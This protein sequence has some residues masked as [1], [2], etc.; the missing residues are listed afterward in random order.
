M[1][2]RIFA[3]GLALMAASLASPSQ[4][5]VLLSLVNAP[6]Q[7]NTS[8]ALT[9]TAEGTTT[10]VSIAGYQPLA[11]EYSKQNGLF[12]NGSGVDLLDSHWTLTSAARGS[13]TFEIFDGSS[14]PALQFG[15]LTVGSSD[16]YSQSI[17]TQAGAS[18]TLDFLYTNS[19]PASPSGFLVTEVDGGLLSGGSNGGTNGGSTGG[20]VTAD[21]SGVAGGV[22]EPS[23]WALMLLGFAGLGF[24][25]YRRKTGNM[26]LAGL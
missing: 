13:D 15:S 11:W 5:L 24:A 20:S 26:A 18:Y 16:T 25:G 14:V 6:A 2:F 19:A 23:T 1:K 21:Y 12:L 10:T 7:T 8:Y 22:P 17:A 4:A 3:V 9:F